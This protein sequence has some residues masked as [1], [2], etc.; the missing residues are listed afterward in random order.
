MASI[1]TS[2]LVHLI[3]FVPLLL[4]LEI[5][6]SPG[7]KG[8]FGEWA[9]R[10]AG[11]VQLPSDVYLPLHN[12][13]LR[14]PDGT[15]QID[16]ILVSRYGIFVVETKNMKGWIFGNQG[17]ALWT[18]TLY[19]KSYKVQ[20][21]LRQNYKHVKAVEAALDVP[22][23]TI[24]SV[25]VFTGESRFK[26]AMPVNVTRAGAYADYIKSFR[27]LVL[28]ASQVE[29]SV[30]AIQSGRLEATIETHRQHVHR[31]R[32]RADPSSDCRCPRCG[33]N[34]VLRTANRGGTGASNQFWG[35]AGY[36]KCRFVKNL[37]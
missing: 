12:V 17:Q 34:L 21:P 7:V 11:S 32:D 37:P 3:W 18:Q 33:S 31:L 30:A 23:G 10:L 25:I 27:E 13:T 35:C 6:K 4:V 2:A 26:T 9:V 29:E 15:T 24:H 20:N 5:F 22:A 14:T 28:S 19:R 8:A 36:P 16:H 1:V